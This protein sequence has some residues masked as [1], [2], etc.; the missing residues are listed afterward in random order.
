MADHDGDH[1]DEPSSRKKYPAQL[2]FVATQTQYDLVRG[3]GR[4]RKLSMAEVLR[5]LVDEK[6]NL[7]DGEPKRGE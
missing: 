3:Y 4:E 7:E 5:R 2:P 1:D 6:F